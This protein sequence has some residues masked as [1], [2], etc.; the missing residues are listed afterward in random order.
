MAVLEACYDDG[1]WLVMDTLDAGKLGENM[2][3]GLTETG[4]HMGNFV[5]SENESGTWKGIKNHINNL[6][7]LHP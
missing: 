6:S 7:T 1:L 5:L 2:N 4:S 3:M